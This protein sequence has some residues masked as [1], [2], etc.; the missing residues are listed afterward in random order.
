MLLV[1]PIMSRWDASEDTSERVLNMMLEKTCD[2]WIRENT[3]ERLHRLMRHYYTLVNVHHEWHEFQWEDAEKTSN[4]STLLHW[5]SLLWCYSLAWWPPRQ[6]NLLF[7][8][9]TVV[10]SCFHC[11]MTI[12]AVLSLIKSHMG[13]RS[14]WR[15]VAL[16]AWSEDVS[17]YPSLQSLFS[18]SSVLHPDISQCL[19]YRRRERKIIGLR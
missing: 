9:P 16:S 10:V 7:L 19:R 1:D 12:F 11:R 14:K 2:L 13:K 18:N 8:N 3:A 15:V 4:Y 6:Q 17:T 5:C